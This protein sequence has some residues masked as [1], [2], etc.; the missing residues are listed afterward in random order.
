MVL[1]P[2]NGFASEG[3]DKRLSPRSIAFWP[4]IA[5]VAISISSDIW[6][7]HACCHELFPRCQQERT[8]C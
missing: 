6:E 8:T 5:A 3:L 1:A 7:G 4:F 2:I